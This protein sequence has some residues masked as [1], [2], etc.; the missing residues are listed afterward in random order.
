M[1]LGI[2]IL[3]VSF[4]TVFVVVK[5]LMPIAYLVDRP[6]GRKNHDGVIPL[7]GGLAIYSSV[8]LTTFLFAE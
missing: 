4:V 8:C 5:T 3:V 7:I 6:G 2:A 1:G